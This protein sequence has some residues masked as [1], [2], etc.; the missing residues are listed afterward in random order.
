MN[1]G[2]VTIYD[3]KLVFEKS[4]KMFTLKGDVLKVIT[5]YNFKI[6]DSPD[7]K[8]NINFMDQMHF[9]I[10]SRGKCSRDR[11]LIKN[12]FNKTAI[13]ASKT[14]SGLRTIFPS[15]NPNDS[16]DKLKSLLQ[17]KQAGKNSDRFIQEIVAVIDKELQYKSN[18]PTQHKKKLLGNLISYKICDYIS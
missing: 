13:L 10:R 3:D 16:F 2:K 14:A 8:Q 12:Y 7:A 11:N 1:G 6:T 5:E 17:A 9:D 18:T 4:G 15:E